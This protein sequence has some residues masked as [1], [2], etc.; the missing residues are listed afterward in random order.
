MA[1]LGFIF[2]CLLI[3]FV[4]QFLRIYESGV[5]VWDFI[6]VTICSNALYSHRPAVWTNRNFYVVL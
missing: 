5:L 4:F 6:L 2:A 3:N 1:Y